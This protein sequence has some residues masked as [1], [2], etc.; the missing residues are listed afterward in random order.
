MGG[1]PKALRQHLV[2][3]TSLLRTTGVQPRLPGP[4]PDQSTC[5]Q[6]SVHTG[7]TVAAAPSG[8]SD[9]LGVNEVGNLYCRNSTINLSSVSPSER[10]SFAMS[11]RHATTAKYEP[12]RV[13]R[14]ATWANCTNSSAKVVQRHPKVK[15]KDTAFWKRFI[16]SPFSGQGNM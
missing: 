1:S 16:R 5:N 12:I 15:F 6:G 3:E 9:C 8:F 4:H 7:V 10:K 14:G 2:G 13:I 11:V